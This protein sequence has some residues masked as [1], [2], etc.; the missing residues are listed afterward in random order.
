MSR[1]LYPREERGTNVELPATLAQ[2]RANVAYRCK[3]CDTVVWTNT[4]IE[5]VDVPIT[6]VELFNFKIVKPAEPTNSWSLQRC[7]STGLKSQ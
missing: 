4:K 6:R 2:W 1:Y 3:L 7:V 5:P